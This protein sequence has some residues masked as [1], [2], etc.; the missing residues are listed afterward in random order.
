MGARAVLIARA[1][2]YGLGAAGE[3]GVARAIA[4]LRADLDRTLA[5]LGCASISELNRSYIDVPASWTH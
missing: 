5:L 3:A 1:Y 4:L 2:M